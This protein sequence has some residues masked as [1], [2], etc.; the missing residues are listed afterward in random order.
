MTVV[1]MRPFLCV[2]TCVRQDGSSA[3]ARTDLHFFAAVP[4]PLS[5]LR[6]FF[7]RRIWLSFRDIRPIGLRTDLEGVIGRFISH[8]TL[9]AQDRVVKRLIARM[10]EPA[11]LR[12]ADCFG[13]QHV[14]LI[15]TRTQQ[16][17]W[18]LTPRD[19]LREISRSRAFLN[20]LRTAAEFVVFH[21][22]DH[23]EQL[24]RY[25]KVMDDTLYL[26]DGR[27]HFYLFDLESPQ[28]AGSD[29]LADDLDLESDPGEPIFPEEDGRDA[30]PWAPAGPVSSAADYPALVRQWLTA[31][32][33]WA[34]DKPIRLA[35][36]A[37]SKAGMES[38][39]PGLTERVAE[40][41]RRPVLRAPVRI[42]AGPRGNGL[43]NRARRV[44]RLPDRPGS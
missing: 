5:A 13:I 34:A 21:E 33:P 7:D 44:I 11:L 43:R 38:L 23:A 6:A 25:G 31:H 14:C 32:F 35:T 12:A 39:F 26:W 9:N 30:E 28:A 4:D 24:D 16:V 3:R 36:D 37:E 15:D 10:D 1:A 42:K 27:R 17:V 18:T 19:R 20:H 22:Y 40:M 29:A 41:E 2:T 8:D